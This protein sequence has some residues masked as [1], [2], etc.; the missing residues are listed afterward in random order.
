MS[1]YLFIYIYISNS[2]VLNK[3]NA[4]NKYFFEINILFIKIK[5]TI[6]FILISIQ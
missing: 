5:K 2:I 4:L 3:S 1:N 6:I